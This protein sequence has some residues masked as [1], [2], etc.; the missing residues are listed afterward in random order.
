M[1]SKTVRRAKADDVPVLTQIRNDAH[2]RKVALR[3]Y[4]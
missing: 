4:A 2:A 3:D 1:T